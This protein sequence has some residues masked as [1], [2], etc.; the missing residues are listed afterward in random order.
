MTASV[1]VVGGGLAGIT[2][3]LGCAD[4]GY[5]VQLFESRP[6]L[7]G[8]TYSFD[9][10]GLCVDNGQHVF[11]RCCERYRMLL[12]RLGVEESVRLQ[13]RLDIPVHGPGATARLRRQPLPAPL[14]LS[15]T[16]L[17]YPWMST[18]ARARF[19]RAALALRAVDVTDPRTDAASFG[20]WL[21]A[22][23]QNRDAIET[24]WDLVGIATLN[25]RAD[26]VSLAL[27]ATV[28]QI[29][30]LTKADAADI[31]WS[32]VPL[33]RLHADPAHA[34]L[35]NA[36]VPVRLRAKVSAIRPATGRW[37]VSVDG[38]ECHADAVVLAVPHRGAAALLPPHALTAPPNWAA[39]LGSSP[40]INVHV[41]Y[42]RTVLPEP[43]RAGVGTVAQW[44]F[45]RTAAA[46]LRDG[47]YLAV[48]VSA[49]D[50]FVDRPTAELRETFL[51]ALHRLIP[52][53]RTAHVR[54]FFVTREPHATFRPAPGTAR[55]RPAAATAYPGLYLA[56]AWT[57]TG[58][59]ATMEGAVRSGE[60]AVAQLV[61][62]FATTGAGRPASAPDGRTGV[63]ETV[64]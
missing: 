59:P 61:S 44:V 23:G 12:H 24:L 46:G 45:D 30:L 56:G 7:G 58:W 16:L 13:P 57:D 47:Q 43:F 5:R 33:R 49:A 60:A 3:A 64:R 14:H 8:L 22:H 25:A 1:V 31:G 48:S 9:R 19:V 29:G 2:T 36:G 4:A 34:A 32:R 63:R 53:T 40:I 11:L 38:A 50:Q 39:A 18:A 27:A 54:D 42:D 52:A 21:R 35:S 37:T 6:W 17:R 26:D 41:V 10:G 15:W 20:D 62:D 51:P 28:F 55:L